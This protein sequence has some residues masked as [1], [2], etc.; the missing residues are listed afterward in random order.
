MDGR[1][2]HGSVLCSDGAA[3]YVK[4]APAPSKRRQQGWLGL[5]RVNAHHGRVRAM[6]NGRCRGVAIG[7]LPAC[8]RWHRPMLRDGFTGRKLLN[9]AL[10]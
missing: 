5:G 2:A 4:A 1:I 3:A 6:V 9:R 7:Y 8:L 10:A